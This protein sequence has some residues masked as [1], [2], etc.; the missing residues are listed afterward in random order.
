MSFRYTYLVSSLLF[1]SESNLTCS[2]PWTSDTGE[3]TSPD[4]L[5]QASKNSAWAALLFWAFFGSGVVGRNQV[6]G[7]LPSHKI[8]HSPDRVC[9][10]MRGWATRPP[11]QAPEGRTSKFQLPASPNP[12]GNKA[13]TRKS[14]VGIGN[15]E[16]DF[17]NIPKRTFGNFPN[18]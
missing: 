16:F 15:L 18:V 13:D 8:Q 7:C 2:L 6:F 9:N 3:E 17:W 4:D 12:Q 14:G 5:S 11:D 1:L 10:Q